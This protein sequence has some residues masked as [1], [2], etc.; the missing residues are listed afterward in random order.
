MWSLYILFVQS[1]DLHL[2]PLFRSDTLASRNSSQIELAS[3][4]TV[5]W[6]SIHSHI[7]IVIQ[8]L[9]IIEPIPLSPPSSSAASSPSCFSSLASNLL[10][11]D[12]QRMS[13]TYYSVEVLVEK[14]GTTQKLQST[15]S[16]VDN[17]SLNPGILTKG[18]LERGN[19]RD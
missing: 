13:S 2:S 18:A 3:D 7:S 14:H 12:F 10:L 4:Y 19:F 1:L 11:S 5:N 15:D 16:L 9:L 8:C 17:R 6:S